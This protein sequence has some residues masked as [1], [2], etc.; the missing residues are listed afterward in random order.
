VPDPTDLSE[1]IASEAVA[2]L[3]SSGD[4]HSATGRPI[5]DLIEADKYLASKAA[6]RSKRRGLLF[7]KLLP[8]GAAGD[9]PGGAGG[10][11]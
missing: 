2:P 8:P 5:T 11:V 10:C 4:N 6:S 9:A 3:S 1:T 7:T